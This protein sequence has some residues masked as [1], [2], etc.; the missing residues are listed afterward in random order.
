[1]NIGFDEILHTPVVSTD[2]I[3]VSPTGN[4]VVSSSLYSDTFSEKPSRSN[5]RPV[6]IINGAS[7]TIGFFGEHVYMLAV[8]SGDVVRI[9]DFHNHTNLATMVIRPGSLFVPDSA[10]APFVGVVSPHGRA[11][12]IDEHAQIIPTDVS[13]DARSTV[14]WTSTA[15]PVG[16]IW[17]DEN[18][19]NLFIRSAGDKGSIITSSHGISV[20]A[21]WANPHTRHHEVYFTVDNKPNEMKMAISSD[22]G[23]VVEDVFAF[24]PGIEITQVLKKPDGELLAAIGFGSSRVHMHCLEEEGTSQLYEMMRG[25]VEDETRLTYPKMVGKNTY[26]S[27]TQTPVTTPVPAVVQYAIEGRPRYEIKGNRIDTKAIRPVTNQV[28]DFKVSKDYTL[29]YRVVSP[30]EIDGEVD[31]IAERM[32]VIADEFGYDASGSFSPT[33][34]MLYQLGIPV[35]IVPFRDTGEDNRRIDMTNFIPDLIDVARHV[36]YK[37]FTTKTVLIGN[38][39]MCLPVLEAAKRKNAKVEKVIL[40]NPH[41]KV[42]EKIAHRRLKGK[43]V[44]AYFGVNEEDIDNP[45]TSVYFDTDGLEEREIH[46]NVANFIEEHLLY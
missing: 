21:V 30:Y 31:Y 1:M 35:A 26:V 38:D 28:I 8:A 46:N 6:K 2:N 29:S 36:E 7:D 40:I 10:E 32:V 9:L 11:F 20:F 16:E 42:A 34:K 39:D 44:S 22:D 37:G 15:R 12:L 3:A 23:A 17:S 13:V 27:W 45:E 14:L 43:V 41:N 19:A 4:H 33:V 24:D 25:V 5:E 18:G